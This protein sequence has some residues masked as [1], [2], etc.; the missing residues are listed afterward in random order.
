MF[1]LCG[2]RSAESPT[3]GG[4]D[5][6]VLE[7]FDA[8]AV[9]SGTD[10][11]LCAELGALVQ[12]EGDLVTFLDA[13]PIAASGSQGFVQPSP[14]E[15]T[16]FEA[17]L[18]NLVQTGPSTSLRAQFDS[19]G[20]TL[21]HFKDVRG[22]RYVVLVERAPGR[23]GGT[24]A[25]NLAPARN[26]WLEAPHEPYDVGTRRQSALFLVALGPRAL[27]V[28]GTHRCANSEPSLCSG[29]TDVCGVSEA[30]RI[31]DPAHYLPNFF[32]AAHRALRAAY[33]D[34]LAVQIHGSGGAANE[35][36]I[37][38][39]GTTVSAATSLSF[40]MRDLIQARLGGTGLKAFSCNDSADTG[41]TPLCATTNVQGRIDNQAANACTAN[42][43]ASRERFLHIEQVPALRQP[44]SS[45]LGV[46]GEALGELI[47]CTLSGPGLGCGA[48]TLPCP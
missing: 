23:G 46:T 7:G 35:A 38:S 27:S 44:P 26:M 3:D 12:L 45:G 20:Y 30:F 21:H 22:G 8:G 39:N 31:S 28:N 48:G 32:T 33:A 10:G 37:V 43:A 14:T 42:P 17:A 47:P 25:V 4:G 9:D 11:G 5:G 40:R 41:Y 6:G 34:A 15:L 1:S 16:D 13:I 36:A 18:R 2:C 29:T 19:L 24:Y